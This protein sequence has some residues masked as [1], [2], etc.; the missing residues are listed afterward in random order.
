MSSKKLRVKTLPDLIRTL[1]AKG[2]VFEPYPNNS[3]LISMR[4]MT[5]NHHISTEILNVCGQE[6]TDHGNG[7]LTAYDP[8][9]RCKWTL[10][11]DMCEEDCSD[12]T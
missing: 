11:K 3:E 9:K 1:Q 4:H 8:V 10:S 6:V 2:Y 5:L 7:V 12:T